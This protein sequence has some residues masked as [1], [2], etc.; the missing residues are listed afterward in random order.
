VSTLALPVSDTM[1]STSRTKL[2]RRIDQLVRDRHDL[3]REIEELKEV[4]NKYE[5]LIT[6]YK[7]ALNVR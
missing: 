5:L 2:Q 7:R 3:I 6:K 4:L 1:H